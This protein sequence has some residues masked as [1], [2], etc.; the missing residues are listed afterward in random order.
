ME[1]FELI[2]DDNIVEAFYTKN[3]VDKVLL[4]DEI[5]EQYS[6][7]SFLEEYDASMVKHEHWKDVFGVG[8]ES[9]EACLPGDS[10]AYPVSVLY[11]ADEHCTPEWD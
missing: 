3:H 8:W 2:E 6:Y 5:L 7:L 4:F 1:I 9:K 10:D 11:L